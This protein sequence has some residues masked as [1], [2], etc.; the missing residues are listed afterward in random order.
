MAIMAELE[1]PPATTLFLQLLAAR[2]QI[3]L[4]ER[5]IAELK[6]QLAAR[7]RSHAP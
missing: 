1:L 7:E 2:L 4:L 6:N 3:K 5:E